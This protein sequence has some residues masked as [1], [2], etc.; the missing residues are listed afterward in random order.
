ME[1]EAIPK[2]QG[3][4]RKVLQRVGNTQNEGKVRDIGDMGDCL[5]D[6]TNDDQTCSASLTQ[7]QRLCHHCSSLPCTA[8]LQL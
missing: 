1:E 5:T 6:T 3:G 8:N 4:T 7:D 2:L